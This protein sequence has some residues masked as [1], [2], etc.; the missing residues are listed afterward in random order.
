MSDY[1]VFEAGDVLLQ[2]EITL[3]DAK[4]VYKTHGTLNNDGTN[5]I[6]YPT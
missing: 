2:N 1:E 6:I 4:M 5:A 3:R